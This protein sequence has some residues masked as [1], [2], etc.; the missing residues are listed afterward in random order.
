MQKKDLVK[1]YSITSLLDKLDIIECFEQ[2]GKVLRVGEI[3]EKQEQLYYDLGMDPPV[4]LWVAGMLVDRKDETV[5]KKEGR[6]CGQLDN[7]FDWNPV[8]IEYLIH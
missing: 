7:Q 4:S 8:W 3:V 6:K 1:K 2:P 5:L